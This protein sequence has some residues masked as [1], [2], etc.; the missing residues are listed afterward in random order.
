MGFDYDVFDD[1]VGNRFLGNSCQGDQLLESG[2]WEALGR[3]EQVTITVGNF[4][5][6]TPETPGFARVIGFGLHGFTQR[7]FKGGLQRGARFWKPLGIST[8]YK[9][10]C[11]N[12]N[13]SSY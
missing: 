5:E 11:R 4:A 6:Q 1:A 7:P 3:P 12:L 8:V 9:I 2:S 10:I 13:I